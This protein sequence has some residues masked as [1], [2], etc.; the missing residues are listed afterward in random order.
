MKD[1]LVK[2]SAAE[3]R[4]T[5]PDF[6][7][8]TEKVGNKNV[9]VFIDATEFKSKS[10]LPDDVI[11]RVLDEVNSNASRINNIIF[12][13]GKASQE[14]GL[15]YYVDTDGRTYNVIDKEKDKFL[16]SII[17]IKGWRYN[18]Y[19]CDRFGS[20]GLPVISNTYNWSQSINTEIR[21]LYY[22]KGE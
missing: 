1:T 17:E 22:T 21:D 15:Y 7:E 11:E 4:K 18:A 6:L 10:S 13:T 8:H 12:A 2:K 9:T 5:N 20:Y 3:F 14:D 19:E 16:Y